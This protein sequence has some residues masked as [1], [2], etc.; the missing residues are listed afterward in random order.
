MDDDDLT[1]DTKTVDLLDIFTST[2]QQYGV[3]KAK[4]LDNFLVFPW[5]S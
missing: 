3:K 5:K 2:L 1:P 4:W